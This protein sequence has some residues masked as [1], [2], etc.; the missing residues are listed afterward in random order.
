MIQAPQPEPPRNTN[1]L[2]FSRYPFSRYPFSRYA[3]PLKAVT[4]NRWTL[5]RSQPRS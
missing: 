4:T 5:S 3:Q 2:T 1:A